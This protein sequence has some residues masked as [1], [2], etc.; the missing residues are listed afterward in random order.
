MAVHAY[1]HRKEGS[2]TNANYWYERSG[3]EFQREGLEEEWAA[4]VKGLADKTPGDD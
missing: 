2:T 1:L 4:L 3:R